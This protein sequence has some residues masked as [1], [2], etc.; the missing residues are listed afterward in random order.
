MLDFLDRWS[1]E[2]GVV[3]EPERIPTVR[4]GANALVN[5]VVE[6][7]EC[8]H[9][10]VLF[11]NILEI[12][13]GYSTASRRNLGW[14]FPRS[15]RGTVGPGEDA[16]PPARGP[17][18]RCATAAMTLAT[19]FAWSG[20]IFP[21]SDSEAPDLTCRRRLLRRHY[22]KSTFATPNVKGQRR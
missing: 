2:R 8:R 14:Q 22:L 4:R 3:T 18:I 17:T 12:F 13:S 16:G 1:T 7:G 5:L 21:T 15:P 20:R 6:V 19:G 11:R 9:P 10:M